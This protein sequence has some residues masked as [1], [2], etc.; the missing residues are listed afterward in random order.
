MIYLK[1]FTLLTDKQ[2]HDI[3]FGKEIRRIFRPCRCTRKWYNQYIIND[4]WKIKKNKKE[5]G[6]RNNGVWQDNAFWGGKRRKSK[7]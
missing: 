3:V 1:K 2:E 5:E 7:M 6:G 4:K